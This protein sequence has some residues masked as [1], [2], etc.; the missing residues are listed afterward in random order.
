MKRVGMW[1]VIA[2]T[3][4]ARLPFII[5]FP[6]GGG[7]WDI[8]STVAEN[9]LRGCGVSLSPPTGA[10]CVPH[11]GGNHLPG[12]PVF[13]ALIWTISAHSDMAIRIAQ[14]LLYAAAVGWMT[15]AVSR[16]TPSNKAALSVGFVFALSPLQ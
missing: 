6:F 4:L 11:F 2:A 14:L 5:L 13:V 3:V 10:E 15:Q 8:Y 16:F 1:L 9:I 12:F 7:D